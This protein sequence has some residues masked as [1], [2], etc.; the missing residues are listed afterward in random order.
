MSMIWLK[1]SP[2]RQVES[3]R[4]TSPSHTPLN[5]D[6]LDTVVVPA[7]KEGFDRVFLGADQWYALH[8]HVL[9]RPKIK[10]IAAY[11]VAPISAIT[12]IAPVHS[13]EPWKDTGKCVIN[14]AKKAHEL[15]PIPLVKGGRVLPLRGIRY[16][17]K[18]KLDTAETLDDVW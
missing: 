9:M 2:Y 11:Q 4:S 1:N 14:F 8:V 15:G 5:I 7:R 16:A 18:A 13:I 6:D 17:K 12:H 3:E 10:Y